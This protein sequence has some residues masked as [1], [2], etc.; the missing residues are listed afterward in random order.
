[1]VILPFIAV[2]RMN[3]LMAEE[4]LSI[5]S[6]NPFSNLIPSVPVEADFVDN[7]IELT[8]DY[9]SLNP[10]IPTEASFEETSFD[11]NIYDSLVKTLAPLFPSEADFD[12]VPV[13]KDSF[14]LNPSVPTTADFS[15]T[16]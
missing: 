15:D 12:D 16:F 5:I 7:E 3:T 4:N 8:V 10:Y 2:I 9:S 13:K 6:P 1:M 11:T 14:N